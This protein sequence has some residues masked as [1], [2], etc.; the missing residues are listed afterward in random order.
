MVLTTL[1]TVQATYIMLAGTTG[2]VAAL[3]IAGLVGGI[4]AT[5]QGF[6]MNE[7]QGRIE[8]ALQLADDTQDFF[9]DYM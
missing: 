4:T 2:S 7:L 9:E 5:V 3:I 8:E 1:A 6:K